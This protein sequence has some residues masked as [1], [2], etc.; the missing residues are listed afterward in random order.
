[1]LYFLFS[2]DYQFKYDLILCKKFK[3]DLRI[4]IKKSKFDN[5]GIL[6]YNVNRLSCPEIALQQ[7]IQHDRKKA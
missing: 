7:T 3:E 6:N 2:Y 1:M 5:F 4:K